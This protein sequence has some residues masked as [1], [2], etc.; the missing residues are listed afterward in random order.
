MM[1]TGTINWVNGGKG[2]FI[3]PDDG[4]ENVLVSSSEIQ[5]ADFESLQENQKVE[6][7]VRQGSKGLEAKNIRPL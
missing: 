6:Y 4:G 2:G 3:T 1:A 7:E 5:S